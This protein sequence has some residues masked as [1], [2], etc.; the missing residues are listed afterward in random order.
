MSTLNLTITPR[1]TRSNGRYN[2]AQ[3]PVP[4]NK[5]ALV[6]LT[7]DA[8][9]MTATQ[10]VKVGVEISRDN[11]ATWGLAGSVQAQGGIPAGG[12][13]GDPLHPSIE[14]EVVTLES[15]RVRGFMEV[16]GGPFAFGVDLDASWV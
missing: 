3:F 4:A 7:L 1:L 6:K 2:S 5:T 11:G 13:K 16:E 12:T 8:S 9:S 15:T 10:K 14:F